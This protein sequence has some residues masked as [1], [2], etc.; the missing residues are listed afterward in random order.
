MEGNRIAYMKNYN[1]IELLPKAHSNQIDFLGMPFGKNILLVRE[2]D[3]VFSALTSR[4]EFYAW[5]VL[6]GMESQ[7]MKLLNL[8]L[9]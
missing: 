3:G 6:T 2:E 4:S 1:S 5:N 8:D 9:G 7:E